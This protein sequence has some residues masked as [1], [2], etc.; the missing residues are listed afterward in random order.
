MNALTVIPQPLAADEFGARV[1]AWFDQ[2][3]R[4]DLPW[5]QRPTPYRVWV[6]EIMLQQTQ[7]ATV[8][9]YFARFMQRFPDLAALAI[10]S[11][12]EVLALWSG[13]G[14]Y[15]R[16]RNLHTAAGIVMDIHGGVFPLDIEAVVALPG[17]GR[18][19]AGAI[20]SL[21]AGQRHAILDGNVKRVLSR[22]LGVT[23]WPGAPAVERDLW[24][25][26]ELYTPAARCAAYNQAMM[27]LGATLCTR[28]RPDCAR[29]PLQ[30]GCVA[31]H[32]GLADAIPASKPRKALPVKST[33]MLILRNARG[34]VLLQKRPPS[35]IWGG[36]WAL[37]EC[38]V[39]EDIQAW[40]HR[41]LGLQLSAP[42]RGAAWRH[43]FSHFHLD[44]HP[45]YAQAENPSNLVM[46]DSATVWY[47]SASGVD[48]GLAAPVL[49][50]LDPPVPVPRKKT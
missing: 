14:Y 1:L 9:P 5:Q 11:Q 23:A 37:P 36:L 48:R 39:E 29:C 18:S 30:Q 6:S 49:R 3:G 46:E 31:R 24:L 47:N 43:T 34:E 12:D 33:A 45:I 22:V 19:T 44:I 4:K 50:L 32:G 17:I 16:G 42:L 15:A 2:H 41:Q 25:A 21:G 13:L 26:A 35:G 27:D 7:V 40:A 10:A 8:I 20:L 38:A 28:G